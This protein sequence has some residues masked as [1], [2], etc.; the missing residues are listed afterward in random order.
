MKSIKLPDFN[1]E[2]G[3]GQPEYNVLHA[4]EIS[5]ENTGSLLMCFELTDEEVAEIVKTKRTY[6]SRLTFYE[7]FQP[8]RLSVE[9]PE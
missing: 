8:M 5:P 2:I 3:K 7:K 9:M 1:I 6:Y 4:K